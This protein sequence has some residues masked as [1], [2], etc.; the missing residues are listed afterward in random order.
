MTPKERVIAQIQHEETDFIPYTLFFEDDSDKTLKNGALERVNSYYGNDSWRTKFD[1]HIVHIPTIGLG[2]DYG[3]ERTFC[4]DVYGTQWRVDKRPMHVEKPV[5]NKPSLSEYRFPKSEAFFDKGWYEHALELINEEEKDHFMIADI[6]FG[7]FERTWIMRGFENALVDSIL[8]PH[9]YQEL[10]HGIFEKYMML[11]DKILTLPIDGFMLGDDFGH[12]NGIMIGAERWRKYF[13]PYLAKMYAK[14]H[15]ADK[16]TIH[17]MCGSE[18]EIL[19]DLI[20]IG[21]D[22]Y[23]SVQPEA[24]NNS[25][26]RLKKLYGKHITFWGGLGSQSIIPFGRPSEIKSE[27]RKL[28]R[29]M[30][31]GGGYILSCAKPIQ[32]ETPTENAVALIEVFAEQTGVCM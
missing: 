2:V 27:V 15:Q 13:K 1:N 18:A 31:K 9:F 4:T 23:E 32:P 25:P 20:D 7:L 19:P 29:E 14:I 28:C 17:H 11:L 21:L 26:Y 3:S 6:G 24:K 22:V 10:V 5:L 16:Y 30:G 12:Q 8:H